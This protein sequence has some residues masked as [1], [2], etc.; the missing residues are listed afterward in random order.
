M[1][2]VTS[3]RAA[4]TL[5]LV[6][7]VLFLACFAS[8]ATFAALAHHRDAVATLA[9]TARNTAGFISRGETRYAPPAIVHLCDT[10]RAAVMVLL[11]AL[12]AFGILA[13]LLLK[14]PKG[15]GPGRQRISV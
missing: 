14:R 1:P 8:A 15:A 12:L 4:R 7:L 11:P 9:P 6:W 5:A 10:A 3:H 2:A 13:G